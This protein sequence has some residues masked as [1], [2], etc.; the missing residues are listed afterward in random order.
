MTVLFSDD[1]LRSSWVDNEERTND[2]NQISRCGY[3]VGADRIS[4]VGAE[5][6][7]GARNVRV[8][9]SQWRSRPW[10]IAAAGG[11]DG[12]GAAADHASSAVRA[13]GQGAQVTTLCSKRVQPSRA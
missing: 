11:L 9:L 7:R 3:S 12:D 4:R 5:H 8:C 10:R 6:D 2:Q 1:P 13:A